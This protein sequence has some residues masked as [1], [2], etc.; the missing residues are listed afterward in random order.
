[1]NMKRFL[2]SLFCGGSVILGVTAA[3]A[4][5]VSGSEGAPIYNAETNSYFQRFTHPQEGA[6]YSWPEANAEAMRK[7]YKGEWGRLAVVKD[8]KILE[9]VRHN[10]SLTEETWIGGR[11]SC[12][13]RK[14]VWVDGDVQTPRVAGMWHRQWYRSPR[15]NCNQGLSSGHYMSMF[16]TGHLAGGPAYWQASGP[17]KSFK[18]YLVEYPAPKKSK[19]VSQNSKE[20]TQPA[21]AS[22]MR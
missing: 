9:F 8:P 19:D 3:A 16:L 12:K 13:Y 11:F 5:R 22:K 4:P 15:I 7:I 10:F 18:Y 1:M 6:N 21:D 14:L 20:T 2:L 17:A